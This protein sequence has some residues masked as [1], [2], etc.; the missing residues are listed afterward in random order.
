MKIIVFGATDGTG[1]EILQQALE[2]G[3]AVTAFVRNPS[4]RDRH[5]G[6]S[7]T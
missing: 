5:D 4:A 7:G 1:R 3:H 6:N 2:A